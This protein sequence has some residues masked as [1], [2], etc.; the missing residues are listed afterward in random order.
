[1]DYS[2]YIEKKRIYTKN[3]FIYTTLHICVYC[4]VWPFKK[5]LNFMYLQ[6]DKKCS[7]LIKIVIDTCVYTA[8][9]QL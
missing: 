2:L 9:K 4:K 6:R 1:M 3:I 5:K 8:E 7:A